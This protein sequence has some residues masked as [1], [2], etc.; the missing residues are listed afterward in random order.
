MMRPALAMLALGLTAAAPAPGERFAIS[1]S[2]TSHNTVRLQGS[3]DRISSGKLKDVVYVIDEDARTVERR[4]LDGKRYEDVC[5]AE[6]N[7]AREFSASR[8]RIAGELRKTSTGEQPVEM[9]RVVSFDWDRQTNRLETVYDF[10]AS[11]G[12]NG[13]LHGS[14]KCKPTKMPAD[15]V[16]RTPV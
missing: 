5:S 11:R 13:L 9:R 10:I 8:I 3:P 7:C 16:P 12:V 4:T 1:C 14:L 2:G 15:Y 6:V